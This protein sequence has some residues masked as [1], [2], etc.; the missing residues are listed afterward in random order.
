MKRPQGVRLPSRREAVLLAHAVKAVI[1]V[2]LHLW[3]GTHHALRQLIDAHKIS[4]TDAANEVPR[5]DLAET[6]WSVRNASRLVPGA[7]CLTQASAGQLL[8]AQRGYAS[9]IRL[10]VPIRAETPG[11]LAPH[12]WLF[13]DNIIV[14]GGS[15]ADY[16][17]HRPLHDF[18]T[19]IT[20]TN[21]VP[22]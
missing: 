22:T 9:T 20:S 3:R 1:Q 11:K 7:T 2:R 14:L 5:V 16:A 19:G 4:N 12:A 15:A 17:A 8:L 10:S 21:I 13:S 18:N 6:A